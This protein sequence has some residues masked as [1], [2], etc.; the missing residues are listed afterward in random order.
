MRW[1]KVLALTATFLLLAF[2]W[3]LL[4]PEVTEDDDEQSDDEVSLSFFTGRSSIVSFDAF[5]LPLK[6]T[7]IYYRSR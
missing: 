3:L 2:A 4:L 6:S 5:R 1:I 7:Y